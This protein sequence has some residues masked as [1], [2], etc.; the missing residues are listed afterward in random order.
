M[1]LWLSHVHTQVCVSLFSPFKATAHAQSQLGSDNLPLQISH[2]YSPLS[3]DWFSQ[4]KPL[5]CR[6]LKG[7]EEFKEKSPLSVVQSGNRT[8]GVC[9][10]VCAHVKTL[11][12]SFFFAYLSVFACVCMCVFPRSLDCHFFCKLFTFYLSSQASVSLTP[13][14]HRLPFIHLLH[15]LL[16]PLAL[17]QH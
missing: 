10:F 14:W 7:E 13:L 5:V 15:C 17:S 2:S 9:V 16:Q 3:P 1:H 6:Q 4:S 12:S 8:I 11:L